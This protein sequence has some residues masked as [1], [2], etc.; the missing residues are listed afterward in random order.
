MAE[1]LS[2]WQVALIGFFVLFGGWSLGGDLVD[3]WRGRCAPWF[4]LR[5]L[6]SGCFAGAWIFYWLR[7][8]KNG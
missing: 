3:C 1:R 5:L 7:N 6:A 2:S 4:V 8:E